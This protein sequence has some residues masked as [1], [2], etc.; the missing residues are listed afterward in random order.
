MDGNSDS[1]PL[2]EETVRRHLN[3]VAVYLGSKRL[4]G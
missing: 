2:S 1:I 4:L 3:S